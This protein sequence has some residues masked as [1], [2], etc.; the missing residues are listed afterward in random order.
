MLLLLLL[1]VVVVVELVKD[2]L[3]DRSRWCCEGK[4][5]EAGEPKSAMVASGIWERGSI[6]PGCAFL[7]EIATG[8]E[9][10]RLSSRGVV[11]V[12]SSHAPE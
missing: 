8:S 7:G 2:T 6:R 12:S 1:V 5:S 4:P 11:R 3:V 9:G 10:Y